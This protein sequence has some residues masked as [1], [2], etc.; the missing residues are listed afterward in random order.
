MTQRDDD[1]RIDPGRFLKARPARLGPVGRLARS[2]FGRWLGRHEHWRHLFS[3][4]LVGAPAACML[5]VQAAW[6][7]RLPGSAIIVVALLGPVV[8]AAYR[9][10]AHQ[11]YAWE[12]LDAEDIRVFQDILAEDTTRA[13]TRQAAGWLRHRPLVTG[14]MEALKQARRDMT[15]AYIA[16][17]EISARQ[18]A[19]D[20]LLK[21][22]LGAMAQQLDLEAGTAQA[23]A[24]TTARAPRL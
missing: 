7:L 4:L 18:R 24:G 11:R 23:A 22:P 13:W 6:S 20:D 17:L 21:G 16:W 15:D 19:M 1:P 5:W 2:R 14:D 9:W 3:A 12:D 8:V 10:F